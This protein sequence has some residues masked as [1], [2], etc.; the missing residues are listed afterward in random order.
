MKNEII[1]AHE[2]INGF[3]KNVPLY[4]S[5][6]FSGPLS[7]KIY[8]KLENLQRTG[9]FKI[10]GAL[11]CLIK[12]KDKCSKGVVAASAGNHAQGVAFGANRLGF[13]CTIAMPE[14]TP[15]VKVQNTKDYGA[16]VIQH[17]ANY[18]E[19]YA[20]A[21][22]IAENDGFHL[23][24]PFDDE[25]VIA[26]QGT[27][28]KEI[29]DEMSDPDIILTPVG[30]GGLAAGIASYI[31]ETRPE[32]KV[33]GIQSEAVAGMYESI[34]SQCLVEASAGST[35]AEGIA[36]R[37]AGCKTFEICSK[38]LDDIITVN[39]AEIAYGILSYLEKAKL[40][41]EGAGAAPLAAALSGKVDLHGQKAILVVSGGNIEVNMLSRI[42]NKGLVST[43]R[44]VEVTVTLKDSPGA[45]SDLTGII[46]KEGAN[47][48]DIRHMRYDIK[49]SIGYTRVSLSLEA[50]G[51]EH[52][53][54]IK[55][56]LMK[57]GFD[58]ETH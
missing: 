35:I 40:V 7:S 24:H 38:Y 10:R 13:P 5:S 33:I 9:S 57:K 52:I 46:A 16:R 31:K 17:G 3:V 29:L 39:E 20:K 14:A 19:A 56:K 55:A 11:N 34:K 18:D 2:R 26:G 53:E 48:L 8:F 28:A 41:V 4:Y 42:I 32:T 1:Q 44:F 47:I 45:L 37:K 25:D 54:K 50:K 51:F 23:I 27:I 43:G 22:E 49:A 15:I 6:N 12:N 30:G 58:V 36:V 21:V